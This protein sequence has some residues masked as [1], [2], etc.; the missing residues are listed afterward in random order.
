VKNTT[1]VKF[2]PTKNMYACMNNKMYNNS[3]VLIDEIIFDDIN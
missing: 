2:E 3:E 1:C